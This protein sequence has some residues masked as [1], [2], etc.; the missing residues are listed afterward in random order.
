MT[1]ACFTRQKLFLSK[2]SSILLYIS[3]KMKMCL[4]S[5]LQTFFWKVEYL[6]KLWHERYVVYFKNNIALQK[7]FK[8]QTLP[9]ALCRIMIF[10]AKLYSTKSRQNQ[11]FTQL[12]LLSKKKPFQ[13]IT[14]NVDSMETFFLNSKLRFYNVFCTLFL[15]CRKAKLAIKILCCVHSFFVASERK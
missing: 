4:Q 7:L 9:K 1:N 2:I 6:S 10:Q 5:K 13:Q 15:F 3:I 12:S 8:E 14:F 11:F